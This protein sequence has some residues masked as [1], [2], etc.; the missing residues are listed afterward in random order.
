[1]HP[2]VPLTSP[3]RVAGDTPA[4]RVFV[5]RVEGLDWNCPQ[6]ITPRFTA[7]ELDEMLARDVVKREVLASPAEL[8][9][10]A[11]LRAIMGSGEAACIAIAQS[12]GMYIASDE[13]R[14]F[15]REVKA[16]VGDS[17]LMTTPGLFVLAIRAGLLTIDGADAAKKVLEQHRFKMRF[18][19]CADVVSP[20]N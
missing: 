12:R 11:E 6:H 13:R 5:L 20:K 1:M 15:L 3:T 14:A 2:S 16:R 7:E 4:E 18:A 17:K 19:S 9:I 10:Y 8:T